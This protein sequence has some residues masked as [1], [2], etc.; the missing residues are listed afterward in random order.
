MDNIVEI[1]GGP[2]LAFGL[3]VPLPNELFLG[4]G[5]VLPLQGW[6]YSV[7]APLRSLDLVVDGRAFPL[8]NHS[9]ARTDIFREQCPAHDPSGNSLLSGWEGFVPFGSETEEG[10][11]ALALRARLETGDVIERQLGVIRLRHGFGANPITAEWPSSGTRIAI[12]MTTYKPPIALFKAQL[13]LIQRQTHTNW[14]C[15]ISD[16]NTDN[17]TYDRIRFMVKNDKRFVIFQNRTRLNFYEN[18]QQVLCRTPIDA[19]FVALADQDDLWYPQKLE[20]LLRRFDAETHLVYSDARVV[21]ADGKVIS[22]TFWNARR[23]NYTDLATLMMAN[24]ITGASSMIR[25]SL[26][27]DVLP[28][29]KRFGPVFHDHWIGLVAAL[30]GGIGYVDAPLYDYVQHSTGI[31]GHNYNRWPGA[32]AAF[33]GV[34][35]FAPNRSRMATA[36]TA[37]L[38]QALDDYQFVSLKVMLA[39]TLLLRFPHISPAQRRILERFSKFETSVRAALDEKLTAV[40]ARRATLNLE[41]LL[42]WSMVGTRLRNHA[43]RKRKTALTRRQVENPGGRLLDAVV[44]VRPFQHPASPDPAL[45]LTEESPRHIPVLQ[46]GATKWIHHNITPLTL[47]ELQAHPKRV[48][49]LM[50]TINFSYV[51][52]G[53]IGMFNLALRLHREG[54]H[55]RIVLL[56]DTEWDIEDWRR[57]IQKYPGITTLFD[58]IEVICRFERSIPVEVSPDDRFVAT[59]CWSAHVAHRTAQNFP[60]KRFLFMVQ[61]YEPYFLPMGSINA[62]FRQAYDLPQVMLFS[63]Q[64]L[65]E[66]FRQERIGIYARPYAEIDAMVFNNAIQKFYPS[67]E[68]MVRRQRRLLFYARPEEHAARNLFELGMMA[69]A[70]VANHPRGDFADWSF[71]GIGSLGG[72]TLELKPGLPLELVPKQSLEEYIRFMPSFDVGLSLMMTPHPSLVPIEMASAGMWVVTNTFA[73]KTADRLRQISTNLIGVEPTVQNIRDGIVRAMARVNDIE[74]RL[75]G[76]RVN[77][78]TSWKEAISE[79][80]LQRIRTFLG[81]P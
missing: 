33:L 73:N 22:P 78:P 13:E 75:A 50:S 21:D 5:T 76:A 1:A 28:F 74:G 36:A 44:G 20:T 11:V 34:A 41:G 16:D 70:E 32:V 56:E 43:L 26:L 46:F 47:D 53:Y 9:W 61:E 18:F 65:Q 49:L 23:N 39:R 69:I 19:D 30:R 6:C 58:D 67:R 57:K 71:H 68:Q 4:K 35:K 79:Q 72:N 64:L 63:T 29:P 80:T 12:C 7:N 2:N 52:G 51:F 60:E 10:N 55:A 17:E 38:K 3:D 31:I 66:F 25:A 62:L 24:T 54:Y 42:L 14:I 59:S 27:P 48:N 37:T 8:P 77:W 15:I 40:K 81:D 45:T